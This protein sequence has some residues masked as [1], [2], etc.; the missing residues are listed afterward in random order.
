MQRRRFPRWLIAGAITGYVLLPAA[1]VTA[2]LV[3][4]D[5]DDDGRAAVTAT[6]E[7]AADLA[8]DELAVLEAEGEVRTMAE[9]HQGMMDQMRVNASPQMVQLM[10][11]DPMWQMM[12]SGQYVR[13]LEEHEQNIDRMLGLGG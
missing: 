4:A 3:D 6:T 5:G 7:P 11:D 12:R 10:N 9:L 8:G 13:L 2:V 1:V